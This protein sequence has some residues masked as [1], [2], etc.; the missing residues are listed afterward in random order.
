MHVE[1][2]IYMAY[3]SKVMA[4]VKVFSTERPTQTHTDRQDKTRFPVFNS[5]HKETQC[6]WDNECPPCHAIVFATSE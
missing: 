6:P 4:K 2:E 5:G 1:C 3:G